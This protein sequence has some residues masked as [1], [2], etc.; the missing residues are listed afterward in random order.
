MKNILI[1]AIIGAAIWYWQKGGSSSSA[2]DPNGNAAV[3][4]FT[5]EDCGNPCEDSLSELDRRHVPYQELV[6]SQTDPEDEN[7][8]RWQSLGRGAFPFIVAG[9]E[10]VIGSS[11][12]QLATLLAVNFGEEYLTDD[13]KRYFSKHFDVDGSPKIVLYGTAWCPG[14]AKLREEMDS[15]SVD[16]VDIDVEADGE[17][18]KKRVLTTL[19]IGGYPAT[20]YGYRRLRGITWGQIKKEI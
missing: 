19:E 8:K 2:V 20:W 6:V 4:I 1:L 11:K 16:Y 3:L 14:C 5:F 10:K 18:A 9:E 13:E 12:A 17:T 7:F 15:E